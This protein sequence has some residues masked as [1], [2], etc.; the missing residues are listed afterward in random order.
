MPSWTPAA[1][2]A[3]AATMPRPS[4]MPPAAITG[5]E[6][7]S[8]TCGTRAK[9]VIAPFIGSARKMPLWPPASWPCAI[10]ASTPR[11]SSQAASAGEVAEP[12]TMQPACLTAWTTSGAGRPKWKETTRGRASST[13]ASCASLKLGQV[14]AAAGRAPS[15]ASSHRPCSRA[16]MAGPASPSAG[17]S[18]W[19]KKLRWKGRLVA[20]RIAAMSARSL[21]GARVVTPWPPSPPA[22]D[23]AAASAGVVAPAIGASRIGCSMPKSCCRRVS[24]QVMVRPRGRRAARVRPWCGGAGGGNRR[25]R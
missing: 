2:S 5:S 8:A 9:V 21:S 16:R 1:P 20:A 24:G 4:M 11:R 7:A 25:S 22:F 14:A 10:T 6:M 12:S 19:A 23:T 17:G 3:S 15:P 18:T 13:T